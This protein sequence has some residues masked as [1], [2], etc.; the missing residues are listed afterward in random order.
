[1]DTANL[2]TEFGWTDDERLTILA[3]QIAAQ[4]QTALNSLLVIGQS[5]L[6]AQ[7]I[8]VRRGLIF[9]TWVELNTNFGAKHAHKLVRFAER[10]NK[11][12]NQ[13]VLDAFATASRST[14]WLMISQPDAVLEAVAKIEADSGKP[15]TKK[16]IT[17]LRKQLNTNEAA[18]NV[19]LVDNV[20]TVTIDQEQEIKAAREQLHTLEAERDTINEK[21]Q[22]A[23]ESA[24]RLRED[25]QATQSD[26]TKSA[27]EIALLKAKPDPRKSSDAKFKE[28]LAER[29][30][31]LQVIE[32]R[33]GAARTALASAQQRMESVKELTEK[34]DLF[35][36][37]VSSSAVMEV[38]DGL[39][40]AERGQL[41][42]MVEKLLRHA[43]ALE[44]IVTA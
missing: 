43:R 36:R 16:Q 6:E 9:D 13:Q 40:S 25:L 2:P 29:E 26:L 37:E 30:K 28:E 12:K 38:S 20:I 35:V 19:D 1:M 22:F 31:E 21:L 34:A 10:I 17:M 39:S 24:K 8:A 33:I 41:L 5:L 44:K 11:T 27:T 7:I 4:E 14:L 15:A 23:Q 42:Q 3:R 18:S 32:K